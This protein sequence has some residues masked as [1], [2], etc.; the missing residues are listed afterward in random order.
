MWEM[1]SKGC[2]LIDNIILSNIWIPE[3]PEAFDLKERIQRHR[4]DSTITG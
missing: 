3:F 4:R 1:E 2:N